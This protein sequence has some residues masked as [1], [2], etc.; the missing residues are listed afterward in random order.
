MLDSRRLLLLEDNEAS[1][2][3]IEILQSPLRLVETLVCLAFGDENRGFQ[4]LMDTLDSVKKVAAGLYAAETKSSYTVA[5]YSRYLFSFQQFFHSS[6]RA[7][8]GNVLEEIIRKTLEKAGATVYEKGE[9]E[10]VLRNIIGIGTKSGHDVDVL[11][12]KDNNFLLIQVR[13]RDDTGGTTAK[14]SLVELLADFLQH[15]TGPASNLN[16]L[17]YVIYVWEPLQSGQKQSLV[18]KCKSQ[19]E[20]VT[21]LQENFE[22]TLYN[23]GIVDLRLNTH[24]QLIYGTDEFS[25]LISNFTNNKGAADLLREELSLLK[26]WDDMWLS[27]AIVSLELENMKIHNKSNFKILEEKLSKEG[28]SFSDDDIKNYNESSERYALQIFPK[29]VEDT[30]PVDS[31]SDQ[32]NY[33]RDL[34]LL[35]MIFNKINASCSDILK[36]INK[37]SNV[38][39]NNKEKDVSFRALVDEIPSTS[40][41]THGSYYY[42]AR[43]IPQVVRYALNEYTSPNDWVVDPFAGSGTVGIE[44][45]LTNRN[46][47]LFDINPMTKILVE[48]KTVLNP[49]WTLLYEKSQKL[50][51]SN[52]MFI[53]KWTHLRYWYP[54]NIFDILSKM[55]YYY[56]L[57]PD[58][59]TL[60]ALLKTSKKFSYADDQVPKLFKSKRKIAF[61]ENLQRKNLHLIIQKFYME[62]LKRIYDRALIFSKLYKGG[63]VETVITNGEPDYNSYA[64]MNRQFKLLLTSPPYGQAHEYIRSVK[65]ELAW[66]NYTGV[67]ITNLGKL[68]IPYNKPPNF[69]VNSE[70]YDDY[71]TKVPEKTRK[72][73]ETYF[74]SVLYHLSGSSQLISK[75]GHACIFIGNA[76]FSGLEIPFSKVFIEHLSSLGFEHVVTLKDKIRSRKLFTGRNNLSPNGMSHEYLVILKRHI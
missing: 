73:Y 38:P 62:S 31:P 16:N 54:E 36:K 23:G 67:Q 56:Y 19:L 29:W 52:E 22:E 61:I 47:L 74:K 48:A 18:N 58:P 2:E 14:G 28:L 20:R 70:T 12:N 7:R 55:W 30:L 15:N 76:T 53:P 3:I 39:I 27:Y 43:F 24:L 66:L 49:N 33:L 26:D 60:L 40:Y 10:N 9:H 37:Q 17:Y 25:E 32:L 46:A 72:L 21:P 1:K 13:S 59:L 6:Y 8:Q 57:D 68:E 64:N 75:S 5:N 4:V 63:T 41:S 45:L 34:I 51:L 71:R 11:A 50:F 69:E 35:K 44:A 42:P 65:L